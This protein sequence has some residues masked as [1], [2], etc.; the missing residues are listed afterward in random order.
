MAPSQEKTSQEEISQDKTSQEK[1]SQERASEERTSEERACEDKNKSKTPFATLR[2]VNGEAKLAFHHVAGQ[3][4]TC[5]FLAIDS[6]LIYD[7]S[8]EDFLSFQERG[9]VSDT[10]SEASVEDSR[11]HLPLESAMIRTGAYIFTLANFPSASQFWRAGK[12]STGRPAHLL[13]VPEENSIRVRGS[14][15]FFSFDKTTRLLKIN[16][17]SNARMELNMNGESVSKPMIFEASSTNIRI[18]SFEYNLEYTDYGRSHE[19][20]SYRDNLLKDVLEWADFGSTFY[21]PTPQKTAIRVGEW[22]L[23]NP[24]GK[25]ACGT[26][27][28]V[29]TKYGEIAAI[30]TRV[31]DEITDEYIENEK[32]TLRRITNLALEAGE[33]RILRLRDI[34]VEFSHVENHSNILGNV[35]YILVPYC[36]FTLDPFRHYLDDRNIQFMSLAQAWLVKEV[37]QGI[38]FLHTHGF[39]HGD[40]KPANIGIRSMRPF[41]AHKKGSSTQLTSMLEVSFQVVLLDV[42]NARFPGI[43]PQSQPQSPENGADGGTRGF[44]A[45]ERELQPWSFPADIWSVGVVGYGLFYD[46]PSWWQVV[47]AWRPLV[48]ESAERAAGTESTQDSESAESADT[49]QVEKDAGVSANKEGAEGAQGA[50]DVESGKPRK[51]TETT[52]SAEGVVNW[53]QA[54]RAERAEWLQYWRSAMCELAEEA[55]HGVLVAD[56]LRDMLKLTP[57]SDNKSPVVDMASGRI[58]AKQALNPARWQQ[59]FDSSNPEAAD[60]N[61]EPPAKKPSLSDSKEAKQRKDRS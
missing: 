24:V 38:A 61:E 44:L 28:S 10:P 9:Y 53:E 3:R 48:L 42:E 25:G 34:K 58:T 6:Q 1:T 4:D 59:I 56:L 5:E 60:E 47:N 35:S 31:R 15:A 36:H 45:P 49:A 33:S 23:Q 41:K 30:K 46:H 29:T 14:H 22:T 8:V 43:E 54:K 11:E 27:A 40:I 19:F 21:Q 39:L 50:K 12:G 52:E 17:G 55:S 16:K 2:P 57:P 51:D 7:K 26:V 20:R 32:K 13:L 37:T 18:A